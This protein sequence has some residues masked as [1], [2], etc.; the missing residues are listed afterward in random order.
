MRCPRCHT[1][2][3][4]GAKFCLTCGTN[5]QIA[6][7]TCGH[8]LPPQAAF[9]D[10]CGFQVAAPAPKKPDLS[11][12]PLHSYTPK[13]LADNILASQSAL[14]GERKQVTILFA[15]VA[16]FTS[17]AEH[18][19]PEELHQLMNGCF[20]ILT[21][22][23]HRYEGTINQYLGDG[24]MALFSAPIAY[25]DHAQRA[26]LAALGIHRAL[27]GYA[28]QARNR[29]GIDFRMRVGLNTGWVVVGRIGDDLRMD[30]TAQGDTVNLAARMQ[31]TAEPATIR[32][33]EPTKRLVEGLFQFRGL[34]EVQVKGRKGK[35]RAF[36]VLGRAE[37]RASLASL[38][39][40]G[41]ARFVGR[42]KEV[43]QLLDSLEKVKGGYG[44]VVGI[45]GEPGIG[46]SRLLYEF[47]QAIADQGLFLAEGHSVSFG[48]N[49]AY[50]PV[51]E[52]LREHLGVTEHDDDAA[53]RERIERSLSL[54]GLGWKEHGPFLEHLLSPKGDQLQRG[55]DL[56]WLK[57]R[58]FQTLRSV[59]LT[60]SRLKP[61][62]LILE[63]LH[64]ID[65]TSEEYLTFLIDGLAKTPLLLLS[66]YR[67]EYTPPWGEKSYYTRIALNR[68][69]EEE[70]RMMLE[71]VLEGR[72][73]VEE[74]LGQFLS[75]AEGN[76]FFLEELAR[77]WLDTEGEGPK[78]QGG[79]GASLL[80]GTIQGVLT[81][82]I[83]RLEESVKRSL[84][85][86]AVIGREFSATL[87]REVLGEGEE[88][89]EKLSRLEHMELIHQ[90]SFSPEVRYRFKHALT[91]EAA[92]QGLLLA[93]RRELHAQVGRALER[94]DAQALESSYELLAYHY[95][96]SDDLEKAFHYLK[97]AGEKAARLF[98]S[99]EAAAYY[100][101]ALKVLDRLPE[102]P[103]GRRHRMEVSLRL[104]EAS[105]W[106][107][108][109]E[110]N[111]NTLQQV[112]KL[113][114]ELQDLRCSAHAHH[115]LGRL[116][117]LQGEGDR[118]LRSLKKALE[119]AE[120][121]GDDAL[122]ALAVNAIG[123][124]YVLK[125]EERQGITYLE[126]G[127]SLAEGLGNRT[128]VAHSYGLLGIAFRNLGRWKDAIEAC[129]KAI[130]VATEIHN[131]T[132]LAGAYQNLGLVYLFKGEWEKAIEGYTKSIEISERSGDVFYRY[133]SLYLLGYCSYHIGERERGLTL[134]EKGLELLRG[135]GMKITF[136]WIL[137]LLAEI[138]LA[139]GDTEKAFQSCQ[140]AWKVGGRDGEGYVLRIF[141]EIYAAQGKWAEAEQAFLKS[142]EVEAMK[143]GRP[144]V[145]RGSFSLGCLY[146]RSGDS[147]KADQY[148]Q[149]AARLFEELE[150][151]WDLARAQKLLGR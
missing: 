98:A 11:P 111:V 108:D 103:E 18:L 53:I 44:Q 58:T 135:K 95:A 147:K 60:W 62:V 102:D 129:Q 100:Q 80:P 146:Q 52:I 119:L 8:R 104:V 64:W 1:E 93:K 74:V 138:Y 148:L 110:E 24:I 78:L 35:V 25:E 137:A 37:R 76:P 48:T 109:T 151:P 84:Q 56:E 144:N 89:V 65:R 2:N 55:G 121:L 132:R 54:V 20:E 39:Q 59:T 67:P 6:C 75:R 91:Q 140:E 142:I 29:W 94:Q 149:E 68:L 131:L 4:E 69:S 14:E 31:Q 118:A 99:R 117:Y 122:E 38:E 87:L 12:I 90:V 83:D 134:M 105:F 115:W 141:G 5:L 15:D 86:A 113:A 9:C 7:P 130:Q 97:L 72:G 49:M 96:Q 150:M 112:I 41:L 16:N 126:R 63:N 36:E 61:T 145:A 128:E 30:Y 47:K 42:R 50:L 82:R 88:L 19:D 32:I 92:Y 28:E 124:V 77:T 21:Q 70:S 27:K 127:I 57:Q 143:G 125:G 17:I 79:P 34:G 133:Y 10:Q 33:T 46:K 22:E 101:Q 51:R 71:G 114:E 81:A 13:H 107:R 139:L 40:R 85:T 73:L 45:V 23:I 66:T 3:Q 116:F 106:A 123:R 136:G 43:G 120:T 26:I